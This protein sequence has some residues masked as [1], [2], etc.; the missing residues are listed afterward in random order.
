MRRHFEPAAFLS[1]PYGIT[2]YC[3]MLLTVKPAASRDRLIHSGC[4]YWLLYVT[5]TE[6]DSG[7][8]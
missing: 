3:L 8:S 2:C 7:W 6:L 1:Q 4:M 5:V